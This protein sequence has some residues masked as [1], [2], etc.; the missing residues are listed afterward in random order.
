MASD[1]GSRLPAPKR[2]DF[3]LP[4]LVDV[5]TRLVPYT[6]PSHRHFDSAMPAPEQAVELV[7]TTDRPIPIRDLG[8][9][10]YVGRAVI[11]ECEQVEEN[12]YRFL[13]LD[14]ETLE[15]G[16]PITLAWSGEPPPRRPPRKFIYEGPGR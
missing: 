7:V 12:V 8:P 2:P 13:A 6:P 15:Q 5:R 4:E 1:E 16:R 11:T 3:S 9:V 10:L 14:P